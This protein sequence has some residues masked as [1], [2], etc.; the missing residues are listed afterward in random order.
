MRTPA[1]AAGTDPATSQRTRL[2][3][4]V[5]RRQCTTP[6]TG[7]ITNEATRSLDTAARLHPEHQHEHRRH[8]SPAAHPGQAHDE[9]HGQSR[10]ADREI[11]VHTG[12]AFRSVG[13]RA[14]PA[15]FEVHGGFHEQALTALT[16]SSA[17]SGRQISTSGSS[18]SA[19][20]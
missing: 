8:E 1:K 10:Q 9:T 12:P 7:F 17:S 16:T 4:T 15:S 2:A 5:P 11:D 19:W 6:P 3:F 18:G 13:R 20:L 14:R